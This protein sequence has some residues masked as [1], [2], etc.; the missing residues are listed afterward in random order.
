[1]GGHVCDR[2]LTATSVCGII[3][4]E[5]MKLCH[6][7]KFRDVEDVLYHRDYFAKQVH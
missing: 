5:A 2:N 6:T 1:M 4:F 7:K 3:I